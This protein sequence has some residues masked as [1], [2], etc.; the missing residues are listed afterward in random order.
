MKLLF[1]LVL[2]VAVLADDRYIVDETGAAAPVNDTSYV[3]LTVLLEKMRIMRGVASVLEWDQQVP[4]TQ[5]YLTQ[6]RSCY[7]QN[8]ARL[9]PTN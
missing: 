7:Q 5:Y 8:L 4:F 1:L 2:L 9:V 6:N 3:E